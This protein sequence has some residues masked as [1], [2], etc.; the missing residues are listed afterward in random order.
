[1][2]AFSSADLAG[3]FDLNGLGVAVTVGAGTYTGIFR[4]PAVTVELVGLGIE[5]ADPTVRLAHDDVLT[6]ALAAGSRLSIG[7]ADYD[8]VNIEPDSNGV[9]LVQLVAA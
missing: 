3:L 7:G 8:V 1:M 9:D 2:T 5:S 6:A 4:A